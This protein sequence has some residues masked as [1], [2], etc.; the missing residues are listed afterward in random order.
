[1]HEDLIRSAPTSFDVAV[2]RGV[3]VHGRLAGARM[4]GAGSSPGEAMAGRPGSVATYVVFDIIPQS[5][6][7]RVPKL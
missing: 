2:E 7:F 4:L 5:V 1:M 3:L 6:N